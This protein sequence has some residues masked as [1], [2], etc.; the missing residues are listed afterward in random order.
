M[1]NVKLKARHYRLITYLLKSVVAESVFTTL[2]N[3][4]ASVLPN[5]ADTELINVDISVE[6]LVSVYQ[7]LSIQNEGVFADINNDMKI[8]LLQQIN[9]GIEE[10][11]PD[12]MFVAQRIQKIK[13][14]YESIL[15]NYI[16]Q[17]K[18]FLN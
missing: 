3:I 5:M 18:N 1:I 15:E 4:K 16:T 11:N 17:G 12:W 8:L 7:M 9:K 13:D 10:N 14:D 2:N 6:E